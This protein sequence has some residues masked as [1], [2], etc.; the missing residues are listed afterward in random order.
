MSEY[1]DAVTRHSIYLQKQSTQITN[2]D[3]IPSLS[4]M[5]KRIREL[6]SRDDL[7]E[8]GRRD[9][10]VLIKKVEEII[11]AELGDMWPN[12]INDLEV[13]GEYEAEYQSKLIAGI[14]EEEL[15][16]P[17][18]AQVGSYAASQTLVLEGKPPTVGKFA[19]IIS[20]YSQSTQRSITNT[21]KQGYDT[22]LTNQQVIQQIRGTKKNNYQDGIIS[23]NTRNADAIVR[24]G[25]IAYTDAGKVE[26]AKQNKSILEDEWMFLATLDGRTTTAC[27]A[28][29]GEKFK[30]SDKKA[31]RIPRHYRCRSIRLLLV[32]GIDPLVG[33]RA[34]KGSAGGKQVAADTTQDDWLK[35]QSKEFKQDA[36]GAKWRADLFDKGVDI[37]Q[38]VN[39]ASGE[40][41]T[42]EQLK[43]V[44]NKDIQK[45]IKAAKL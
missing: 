7:Q 40:P 12:V 45:A 10:N 37:K 43:K 36:L 3:V 8:L 38:F 28:Y 44:D 25:M 24:T 9:F 22:G 20:T 15:S 21:I 42:L 5:E 27:R 1:M 16:L 33:S 29:D 6:L 26:L 32:K 31:P 11:H 39:L 35:R 34:S 4:A 14:A 19:E 13:L 2:S 23:I 17:T 41:Y 18:A 30:Y